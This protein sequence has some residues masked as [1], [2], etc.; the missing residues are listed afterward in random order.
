[1]K[2]CPNYNTAPTA[3]QPEYSAAVHLAQSVLLLRRQA[4]IECDHLAT[5]LQSFVPAVERAEAQ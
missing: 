4:R 3:N 5:V 2:R 1:M